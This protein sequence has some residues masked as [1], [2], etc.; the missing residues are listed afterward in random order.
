M[1]TL[2]VLRLQAGTFTM[3]QNGCFLK[4]MTFHH[5]SRHIHLYKSLIRRSHSSSSSSILPIVW[6]MSSHSW[7]AFILL[8][9]FSKSKKPALIVLSRARSGTF[10]IWWKEWGKTQI[11]AV[12]SKW[13]RQISSWLM[14]CIWSLSE[15]VQS[16][17]NLFLERL[18]TCHY[19]PLATVL[20]WKYTHL[21]GW[22][23][24]IAAYKF[25][26]QGLCR[27]GTEFQE[28]ILR[29]RRDC[30][31]PWMKTGVHTPSENQLEWRLMSCGS[32][33]PVDCWATKLDKSAGAKNGCQVPN[34]MV[35]TQSQAFKISETRNAPNRR[36]FQNLSLSAS[37]AR[38]RSGFQP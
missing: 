17:Y 10:I 32:W 6:A 14:Q 25:I 28:E 1:S 12:E 21:L 13:K 11:A 8:N 3:L 9:S 35:T 19:G 5:I 31:G 24:N 30:T 2:F 37:N 29:N 15:P 36:L 26:P 7:V 33:R 27:R 23:Q 18:P 38:M 4:M 16:E 22:Q 20:V 34:L